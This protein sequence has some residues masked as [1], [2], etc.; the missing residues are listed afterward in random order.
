MIDRLL[1]A[2]AIVFGKTN[3]PYML[4]DA[5]S[6]NDIYGT[7]NNPWDLTR[8][9]GG[10][11]GGEAATL[12]AGLSAGG[13]MS[14]GPPGE[15][16][17]ASYDDIEISGADLQ[18]VADAAGHFGRD[19]TRA[20]A[21]KRV[22]DR[23]TGPAVVGNRAAHALDRLLGAVPPAVLALPVAERVVGGYLPDRH[24]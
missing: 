22:I 5:Q 9:P 6:Y 15:E 18:T 16:L 4:A 11:S 19:Q 7:T 21:E 1:Q 13:L 23:L 10:S 3:V 12:A 2:G 17:P 14:R 24:L 8:S 20:R